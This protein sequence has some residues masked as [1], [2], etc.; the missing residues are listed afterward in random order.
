MKLFEVLPLQF[1]LPQP[2][3]IIRVIKRSSV[4]LAAGMHYHLRGV[5]KV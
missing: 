3:L 2:F 5:K 1:K 4:M